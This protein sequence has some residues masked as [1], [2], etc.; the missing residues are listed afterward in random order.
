[1]IL[2]LGLYNYNIVT[3]NPT[4]G[5]GNWILSTGFWDDSNS[6]DDSENWVD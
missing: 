5:E 4:G 2:G 6:W 1:M 3:G